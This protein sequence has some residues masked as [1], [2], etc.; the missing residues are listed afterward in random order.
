[1]YFINNYGLFLAE[2]ATIVIALLIIIAVISALSA[3]GKEPGKLIISKL[4]E[5]YDEMAKI[6]NSQIQNKKALKATSKLDKKKAKAAAQKLKNRMFVIHFEGDIRA[7]GVTNLREE[8]T[9]ILLTAQPQD[10]VLV[11]L[12]SPGGVVNGYGLAAS[13]LKRIKDAKIK[14]TVAV[15]KMAASGG[16]MMAA[17]ADRIIAAPF[18]IIG[19]IGVVL[20]LPNFHR[21]LKKH[22]IDFEQIT[23]GQYKRTL[24]LFGENTTEG[25]EKAR[26]EVN[27][28]HTFFKSFIKENRPFVDLDKVASGEYWFGIKA[29]ELQLVDELKTSDDFLLQAK[30]RFDIYEIQY[31][32]KKPLGKRMSL[33]L[34][35]MLEY[36]R[37]VSA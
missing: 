22:N 29:Q 28:A 10:E 18:S 13:Q 23:A 4:N 27:E 25:R 16:Y 7:S 36:F 32:I 2:T 1:M 11:R 31:K 33:G 5:K 24:T 26:E 19:S 17:A 21:L 15:D 37:H 6:I 8:V 35:N 34:S 12:D 20:Q 3:K 30:D 14:L 9:A